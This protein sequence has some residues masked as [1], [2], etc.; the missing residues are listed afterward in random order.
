VTEVVRGDD[1]LWTTPTHMELQRL[2]NLSAVAYRHVPLVVG[3]D[4]ER[5]AKR[6]GAVTFHDL[7][8]AGVKIDDVLIFLQQNSGLSG[9]EFSWERVLKQQLKWDSESFGQ[10]LQR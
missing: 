7:I 1:L 4:G 5:L 3:T 8:S 10:H 6:H 2:L 9:G